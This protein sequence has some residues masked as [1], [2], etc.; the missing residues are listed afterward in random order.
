VREL[1]SYIIR[2]YR[3]DAQALAGLVE[4]VHSS[5]KAAFQS[6]PELCELLSGRRTLARRMARRQVIAIA[7]EPSRED[8]PKP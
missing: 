1:H 7:S 2:I 6:L 4:E 8:G 5:R 3:R